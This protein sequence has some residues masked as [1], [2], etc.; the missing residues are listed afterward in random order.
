MTSIL[1]AGDESAIQHDDVIGIDTQAELNGIA[2]FRKFELVAELHVLVDPALQWLRPDPP[3]FV[4][5]EYV[6]RHLLES[7]IRSCH[8]DL[9]L[10]EP[11]FKHH[12]TVVNI[13]L[14]SYAIQALPEFDRGSVHR[15]GCFWQYRGV[16]VEVERVFVFV[17]DL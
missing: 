10:L 8:S 13:I 14:D 15:L 7:P 2:G 3:G 12:R 6:V 17:D 11:Q 4:V 16:W 1:S 9:S 5:A